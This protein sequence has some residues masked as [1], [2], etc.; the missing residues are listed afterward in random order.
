MVASLP[1]HYFFIG[2]Q[3][4]EPR[5]SFALYFTRKRKGLP[6]CK[7]SEYIISFN[8]LRTYLIKSV[9]YHASTFKTSTPSFDVNNFHAISKLENGKSAY[10][11]VV[12]Y[13]QIHRPY[14][15]PNQKIW[16]Q[17]LKKISL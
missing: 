10:E 14:I 5:L 8:I 2:N 3:S 15:S 7:I 1:K 4:F 6:F 12:K 17:M 11:C 9:Q 13:V 16:S